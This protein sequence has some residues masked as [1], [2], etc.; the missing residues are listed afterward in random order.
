LFFEGGDQI[1][2]EGEYYILPASISVIAGQN[3]VV[4]VWSAIIVTAV[5]LTKYVVGVIQRIV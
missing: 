4:L 5:D 1:F 2:D 3:L